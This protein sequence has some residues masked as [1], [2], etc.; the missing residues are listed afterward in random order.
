[1]NRKVSLIVPAYNV[2]EYIKKCITSIENQTYQ[3]YELIIID[4]GSTD[5]T[6]D[7]IKE[8]SACN[9]KIKVLNGGH[10][11][12]SNARNMGL[13]CVKGD[14]VTFVDSDDFICENY[15]ENLVNWLEAENVDLAICGTNDISEDGKIV[16]QSLQLE[17][18]V[19]NNDQFLSDIVLCKKYTCTVWGKIYKSE[20]LKNIRFDTNISISED[21]KFLYYLSRKIKRVYYNSMPLYNWLVRSS[22]ALHTARCRQTY[23]AL[24]THEEI[25]KEIEPSGFLFNSI[26]EGYIMMCMEC[27][28]QAKVEGDREIVSSCKRKVRK[29][30]G[31]FLLVAKMTFKDKFKIIAK[32]IVW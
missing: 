4:D 10:K 25:M 27:M 11:G 28:K 8:V 31:H 18:E 21:F 5:G 1:M 20:L 19:L 6:T 26:E 2:E 3:N 7:I 12:V 24:S 16:K 15:I 23:A 29:R 14:Y 30:L 32:C 13:D 17:G 22:S 9:S